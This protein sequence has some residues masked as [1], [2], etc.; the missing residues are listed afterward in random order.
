MKSKFAWL[1][2]TLSL[3]ALRASAA[4][5]VQSLAVE[6]V[7]AGHPVGF[8]LLTHPP[9]QFVAYYDAQ[10]RMSVAQRSLDSTNWTITKLPSS[11]GWDSHNYIAMTLDR[12]GLL[13]VSG[14][15]HCAPK[16]WWVIASCA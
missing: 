9:F 10:R 4:G 13:H 14:N 11:V 7:W 1:G 2:M 6:P 3:L 16:R 5:A 15:M 12:A 8:C